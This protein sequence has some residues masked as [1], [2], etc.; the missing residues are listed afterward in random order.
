MQ[1]HRRVSKTKNRGEG[2][3]RSVEIVQGTDVQPKN[4]ANTTWNG[5]HWQ[6]RDSICNERVCMVNTANAV[7]D[8]EGI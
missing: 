7:V 4:M 8:L 3:W 6:R 2:G 5:L 1:E